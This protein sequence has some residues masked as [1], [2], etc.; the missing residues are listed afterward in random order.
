[1]PESIWIIE[2]KEFGYRPFQDGD[3]Q[4]WSTQGYGRKADAEKAMKPLQDDA[5]EYTQY[6]LAEYVRKA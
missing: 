6:R 4:L 5:D 1:M 3:W 2:V